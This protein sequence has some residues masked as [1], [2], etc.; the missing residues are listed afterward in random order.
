METFCHAPLYTSSLWTIKVDEAECD[1]VEVNQTIRQCND[2]VNSHEPKCVWIN[3][4]KNGKDGDLMLYSLHLI[5][6]KIAKIKGGRAE[7]DT[8]NLR[9]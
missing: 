9:K 6:T 2:T 4:L 7:A 3:K 1:E 5:H 8:M